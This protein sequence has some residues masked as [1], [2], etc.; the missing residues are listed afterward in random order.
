MHWYWLMVR[1]PAEILRRPR[2]TDAAPPRNTRAS[3][4]GGETVDAVDSPPTVDA[5][6]A[7]AGLPTTEDAT[8]PSL[9][10]DPQ[11]RP[12]PDEQRRAL[13]D[14]DVDMLDPSDEEGD[15]QGT[16]DLPLG[17]EANHRRKS[18]AD[19]D[20]DGDVT[21]QEGD[22]TRTSDAAD[23]EVDDLTT[24]LKTGGV[25]QPPKERDLSSPASSEA[26]PDTTAA[27]LQAGA[28]TG[29]TTPVV[30]AGAE[31]DGMAND[32]VAGAVQAQAPDYPRD[33][34]TYGRDDPEAY[35]CSMLLLRPL[36]IAAAVVPM[37]TL[38]T[39]SAAAT[40]KPARASSSTWLSRRRR[41][42]TST[43]RSR[44]T[45]RPRARRLSSRSSPISA[46]AAS[47]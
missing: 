47:T 24:M 45:Y 40:V 11:S 13:D 42:G 7:E 10:E 41:R 44:P 21:M 36:L 4:R 6:A 22:D 16:P 28:E 43:S 46:T 19:A 34:P 8:A 32:G 17:S 39:H 30:D 38:S 5:A 23:E 15:K 29:D 20:A 18:S 35:A 25:K 27:G 33:P 3:L 37:R 12:H 26:E 1:N 14:E 31:L 2:P 9:I